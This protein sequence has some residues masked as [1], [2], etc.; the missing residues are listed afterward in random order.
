[1]PHIFYSAHDN[2]KY[3]LGRQI[4]RGIIIFPTFL[5]GGV[6]KTDKLEKPK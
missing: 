1:M 4:P 3:P 6:Q 2:K 5:G